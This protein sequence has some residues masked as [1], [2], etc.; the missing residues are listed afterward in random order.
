MHR[1]SNSYACDCITCVGIKQV[2]NISLAETFVFPMSDENKNG[3]LGDL[4]LS[5]ESGFK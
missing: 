1:C 4:F 3:L 2:T 5:I